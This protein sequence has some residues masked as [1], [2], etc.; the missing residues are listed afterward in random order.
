MI[1]AKLNHSHS[2]LY[3]PYSGKPFESIVKG[4]HAEKH[5]TKLAIN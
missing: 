1:L 4:K 5:E 2:I 3:K